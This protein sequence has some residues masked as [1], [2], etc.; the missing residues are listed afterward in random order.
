MIA[1]A[2]VTSGRHDFSGLIPPANLDPDLNVASD[3]A[4]RADRNEN[5]AN[6]VPVSRLSAA[7]RQMHEIPY[8]TDIYR[9]I[10]K[11]P[12]WPAHDNFGYCPNCGRRDGDDRVSS[13]PTKFFASGTL[14]SGTQHDFH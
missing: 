1:T 4:E 3:L 14:D 7:V 6:V 2:E 13:Q 11:M 5:D 9:L 12:D 8:F 10:F